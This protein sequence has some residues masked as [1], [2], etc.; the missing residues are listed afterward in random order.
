MQSVVNA[1]HLAH[2]YVD[3]EFAITLYRINCKIQDTNKSYL[4]TKVILSIWW[5]RIYCR[6]L[7]YFDEYKIFRVKNR[8]WK[9]MYKFTL[10]C[11]TLLSPA[12]ELLLR[13]R[14]VLLPNYIAQIAKLQQRKQHSRNYESDYLQISRLVGNQLICCNLWWPRN[15]SRHSCKGRKCFQFRILS[16]LMNTSSVKT[17]ISYLKLLDLFNSYWCLVSGH[18]RLW[19]IFPLIK[20]YRNASTTFIFS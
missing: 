10:S 20:P 4:Y 11:L 17:L 1:T 5:W 15:A 2:Q 16:V 18:W 14:D 6:M 12:S 3:V 7:K 19:L 8:R 13:S 9:E